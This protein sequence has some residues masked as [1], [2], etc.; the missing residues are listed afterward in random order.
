MPKELVDIFSL[1]NKIVVI[2][3]A[4]GLLGQKHAEAVAAYGGTPILLDISKNSVDSIAHELNNKYSVDAMG[5]EVDITW[6]KGE[7]V[8]AKITAIKDGEFRVFYKGKLSK[9]IN[10]KKGVT[11][12]WI[13]HTVNYKK[14]KL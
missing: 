4:A 10:L 7:L 1:N 5:F 13:N 14:N 12:V 9:V 3:G 11:K 2:T 8:E 6:D